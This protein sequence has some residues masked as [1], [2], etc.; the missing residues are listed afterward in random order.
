MFRI[1][2]LQLML[3]NKFFRNICLEINVFL[4]VLSLKKLPDVLE[5]KSSQES[6]IMHRGNIMTKWPKQNPL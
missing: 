3:R 4:I 2:V 5:G 6:R 1:N